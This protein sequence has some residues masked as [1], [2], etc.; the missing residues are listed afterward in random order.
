[1]KEQLSLC[2][3]QQLSRRTNSQAPNRLTLARIVER[4]GIDDPLM[5]LAVPATKTLDQRTLCFEQSD[6]SNFL[7]LGQR[8]SKVSQ[9]GSQEGLLHPKNTSS[10]GRII[11]LARSS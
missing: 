11:F 1:M 6:T 5:G 10:S 3:T 8:C 7:A 4:Y 9:Y 2:C